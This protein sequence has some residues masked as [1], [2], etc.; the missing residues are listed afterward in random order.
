MIREL[1]MDTGPPRRFSTD[2][3]EP[4]Y[5]EVIENPAIAVPNARLAMKAVLELLLRHFGQ[6]GAAQFQAILYTPEVTLANCNL[7][8]PSSGPPQP[9]PWPQLPRAFE[10]WRQTDISLEAYDPGR[11]G[12]G[13]DSQHFLEMLLGVLSTFHPDEV[14]PFHGVTVGNDLNIEFEISPMAAELPREFDEDIVETLIGLVDQYGV[15][16][17][18]FRLL[19]GQSVLG[20]GSIEFFEDRPASSASRNVVGL[21]SA[22]A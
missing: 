10:V 12:D 7:R 5:V 4:A 3:E 9:P 18:R 2:S 1:E 8:F 13:W 11:V 17:M 20:N 22:T 19:R 6:N 14:V 16:Q 15:I 21:G